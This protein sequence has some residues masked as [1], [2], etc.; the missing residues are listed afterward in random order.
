[1][2][3]LKFRCHVLRDQAASL[4]ERQLICFCDMRRGGSNEMPQDSIQALDV[5]LK[6]P[7]MMSPLLVP[8]ARAFYNPRTARS[9]Y[10]GA[11]VSMLSSKGSGFRV[12]ILS[13]AII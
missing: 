1:M 7:A 11:E 13:R 2:S 10:G 9:L 4:R 5:A 12:R 3:A 6:H 8:V